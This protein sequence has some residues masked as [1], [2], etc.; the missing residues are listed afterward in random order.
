M[1]VGWRSAFILDTNQNC[2]GQ[3]VKTGENVDSVKN[4]KKARDLLVTVI[5][6]VNVRLQKLVGHYGGQRTNSK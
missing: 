3:H 1:R 5:D 2:K 4:R 6:K